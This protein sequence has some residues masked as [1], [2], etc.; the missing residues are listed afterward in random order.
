ME[1]DAYLGRQIPISNGCRNWQTKETDKVHNSWCSNKSPLTTKA[2]CRRCNSE[3]LKIQW[4]TPCPTPPVSEH[5]TSVMEQPAKGQAP[6][7]HFQT[8]SIYTACSI[9][10]DTST[11]NLKYSNLLT[12]TGKLQHL[13]PINLKYQTKPDS[14]FRSKTYIPWEWEHP[15]LS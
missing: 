7:S 2:K 13:K 11:E 1:N 14:G 4:C 3:G 12:G 15:Q 8:H 10:W 5:S 9:F 6:P